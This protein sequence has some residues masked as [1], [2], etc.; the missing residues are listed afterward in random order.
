[1]RAAATSAFFGVG[2][3][4]DIF[5]VALR[6]PNVLQNLLGEQALSA[7]FIPVYSRLLGRGDEAGARKLAGAIFGLLVCT[8]A[9][10][11]LLGVI[12]ARP[13]VA[14]LAAGYVGDAAEVARGTASV[15]RFELSVRAVRWIFPMTGLLVL[16]AW[17]LGIL[18]SHRRFFLSYVAP[19]AWN[20]AIVAAL[21]LA[22]G[23]RLHAEELPGGGERLLFA[24]CI[25][26]LVGGALQFL[27]QLPGALRALGGLEWSLSPKVPGVREALAAFGPAVAG[28]GVVQIS[29]FLDQVLASFLVIG[30]PSVLGYA[31]MLYLLPVSLFGSSIAAAALPELSRTEAGD[32]QGMARRSRRTLGAAAFWTWPATAALVLF[33]PVAVAGLYQPLRGGRFGAADVAIVA[34][35]V[36]AYALGLLASTSS[37]VLQTTF[38]ALG[39]TRTP[40]RIAALRVAVGA[41]VAVPVMFALDRLPVGALPGFRGDDEGLRLG[42]VGLALGATVGAWLER[43]LLG[44]ALR[45]RLTDFSPAGG[46]SARQALA[47]LSAA[48]PAGAVAWLLVPLHPTLRAAGV[49]LALGGTY[50]A[51]ALALGL[52]DVRR[53]WPSASPRR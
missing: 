50:L 28:R 43:L 9:G 5:Q 7:S 20:A 44:R 49:F 30:A 10:L 11:A 51:V 24:A 39:D 12:A 3:H 46:E 45:R 22:S 34:A 29:S 6:I 2:V 33:A 14:L 36:A 42:A 18:N 13:I 32:D 17:A 8:A 21:V 26:A 23:G 40:A 25:G 47:A 27:V 52:P 38:F 37:R 15:D 53:I 16:S 48:L 31:Q 1:M 41:A 35:T 4:G 19:V